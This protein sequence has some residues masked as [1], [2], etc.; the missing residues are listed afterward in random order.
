MQT[1]EYIIKL[2]DQMSGTMQKVTGTSDAM[3]G[4]LDGMTRKQKELD[5]ASK[6]LSGSIFGLKQRI[7][8]LQQEK[9]LID[10]ANLDFIKA[11]NKE[12]T[13]LQGQLQTLENAGG[14]TPSFLGGL[15]DQLKG[16][17]NPAV[18]GGAIMA[19]TGKSALE[20]ERGMS[21]VNITAQLDG[22]S[23]EELQRKIANVAK[24]NKA[25]IEIAPQSFNQIISQTG[26]AALSLEILDAAMKGSR[27]ASVDMTTVSAALAQSLSVIGKEASALDVLD[28]FLTSKR[29][30]AGEFGDFARY[31]PTMIAG[32]SNLGIHYKEVAGVFA[33]MTGKGQSA[34]K[35]A[36]LIENAFS[37]LGKGNIRGNLKNAGIDVFDETGKIR[38]LVDIFGDLSNVMGAM[39]D[40]QKSSFLEKI[41]IVDKEAKNSFALLTAD[42]DKFSNSMNQTKNATGETDRA[43]K[44]SENGLRRAG[45]LWT[46]LRNIGF[47]FG[48]AV[49]PVIH[50]GID[51]LGAGMAV[52][53]PVMGIVTGL[54]DWWFQG[55]NDGNLLVWGLTAALTAATLA[56]NSAAIAAKAKAVWDG[57]VAVSTGA[58]TK[59]QL[60][61]DAAL[62]ANPVTWIVLGIAALIAIIAVCVNK[63]DGWGK[64]WEV[65]VDFMKNV[66]ELFVESF[67][68]QWSTLTN[69]LMIGLDKIKLGWYKFKEA[70][71]LGDSA[72]NQAMI[73]Q[74][75]EDV[76]KRKQTIVDGARKI[77]E[78]RKKTAASLTWEL[79]WKDSE[80]EE[81]FNI[82]DLIP[83]IPTEMPTGG[84]VDYDELMNRFGGGNGNGK[85]KGQKKSDSGKSKATSDKIDLNEVVANNTK[86]T[87]SYAAIMSKL[88]PVK[89][90]SLSAKVAASA[91]LPALLAAGEVP[92]TPLPEFDVAKTEYVN[93]A[94]NKPIAV[95]IVDLSGSVLSKLPQSIL[96]D[97]N[98]V[99]VP[100]PNMVETIESA[101]T[102]VPSVSEITTNAKEV[103]E[104]ERTEKGVY[105][106]R[107]C[108][109]IVIHVENTDGRG[110]EEIISVVSEVFTQMLDDYGA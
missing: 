70:V 29:V 57:V 34:E 42:L 66:F 12:I 109:Q 110:K 83:G 25:V 38:G 94:D 98:P 53:E 108:D 35:A 54:F 11:Y 50:V 45:D 31:L 80:G 13:S 99:V 37:A 79:S 28:T 4:K 101:A 92:Q 93:E 30:G 41:G 15:K 6:G 27:A 56:I 91:A 105:L 89:I 106:D 26:D 1:Y 102:S 69:G 3:V 90:A 104:T 74:L 55:L 47:E 67:K 17:I 19:A 40:E 82:Q 43:L 36:V 52:L 8:L 65:I 24:D 46:R 84:T 49:L 85:E 76:E 22:K 72:E 103:Y 96:Q 75:N 14:T 5:G 61:L 64:Q 2:T 51:V 16:F 39:S 86:G 71:G 7:D 100:I 77:D 62:W 10:P 23:Y 95:R 73:L 21:E 33:Y 107:F 44:Y 48:R 88:N 63:V 9:E 32:A 97:S 18:I 81:G 58:W 20:F 60:L 78:L 68:F 59:A 87:T